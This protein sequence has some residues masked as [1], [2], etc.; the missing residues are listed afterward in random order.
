MSKSLTAALEAHYAQEVT[1]TALCWWCKRKDGTVFG[2]TDCGFDLVLPTSVDATVGGVT[3]K[4]ATGYT[5]TAIQTTGGLSVDNLDVQAFF[6]SAAITEADI[7]AGKW[8]HAEVR[9]FRVNYL[10]LGDG[11]EKLRRGWLGEVSIG[12]AS[13]VAEL[14][15]LTQILQQPIG[16][17]VMPSCDAD[18]GDSRCKVNLAPLTVTGT[19]TAVASN[20]QFTDSSRAEAAGYFNFGKLTWTGGAN[21]GYAME[22][23]LHSS[24]GVLKLKLPMPYAIS[25]GDT[26]SLYPGCGKRFNED[27]GTKFNN[28]PNFRGFPHLPG[29]DFLLRPGGL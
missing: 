24:G 7:M 18:L 25:V 21:A 20:R 17:L 9:V 28:K 1:T 11:I 3:Y 26:Y 10:S 16:R 27:C 23:D 14:R 8:D 2:F 29:R 5:P 13:F 19:V 22:V 12:D 15:G 4:A 6:D